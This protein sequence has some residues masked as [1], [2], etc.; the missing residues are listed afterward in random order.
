[1]FSQE[2]RKKSPHTGEVF[3]EDARL[4]IVSDQI[5]KPQTSIVERDVASG[6][7]KGRIDAISVDY[8]GKHDGKCITMIIE[9]DPV[10]HRK[11]NSKGC[12]PYSKVFVHHILH[13]VPYMS[14]I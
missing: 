5:K 7:C 9:G 14:Y 12:K 4:Y 6:S 13:F 3:I 8:R 10:H 11:N 1:M 2:T